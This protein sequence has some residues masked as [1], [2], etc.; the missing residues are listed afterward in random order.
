MRHREERGLPD[1][2]LWPARGRAQE[3]SPGGGPHRP[4][5]APAAARADRVG[6]RVHAARGK[7]RVGRL[8]A[9]PTGPVPAR[10]GDCASA[11]MPTIAWSALMSPAGSSSFYFPRR[12]AF[13]CQDIA[14]AGPPKRDTARAVA[15][16]PRVYK[17]DSLRVS[18]SANI[19]PTQLAYASR[20]TPRL[21]TLQS[22]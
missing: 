20:L 10:P 4:R 3:R 11:T 8:P 13:A 12:G 2:Y 9:L 22:P 17:L 14:R 18:R 5:R 1:A 15:P 19:R 16:P 7:D 21:S 6:G